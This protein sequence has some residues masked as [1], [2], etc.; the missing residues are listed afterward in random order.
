MAKSNQI[1]S[2]IFAK[3]F[4]NAIPG[5][6]TRLTSA[7][8]LKHKIKNNISNPL[9]MKSKTLFRLLSSFFQSHFSQDQVQLISSRSK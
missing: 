9:F 8:V 5:H 7:K 1:L 4:N 2:Q 3:F 6:F